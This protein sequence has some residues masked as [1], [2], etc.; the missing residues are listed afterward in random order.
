MKKRT[1]FVS[2]S[3]SSS[4]VVISN[5]GEYENSFKD[6][7]ETIT[8]PFEYEGCKEFGWQTERYYDIWSK[9]NWCALVVLY[10]YE[11]VKYE[12]SSEELKTTIGEPWRLPANMEE[13]LVKVC[14]EKLDIDIELKKPVGEQSFYDLDLG[15]IDHQS[16]PSET[17]ENARMFETAETL[18]DFIANENSY[19][20]NSNDNGGRSDYN[21]PEDYS[22]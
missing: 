16:A 3:S 7:W 8:L 22:I 2:N 12:T 13:L 6:C 14:K 19:I 1:D 4:F 11:S 20:D 15:Y 9:L 5:K 18:Y 17:P 10:R 21:K